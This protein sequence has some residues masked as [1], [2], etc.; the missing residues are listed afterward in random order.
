MLTKVYLEGPLG[1]KFGREWEFEVSSPAEALRMVDA[2]VPGVFDWIKQNLKQFPNYRVVIE[3]D[4]GHMEELDNDTVAMNSSMR[5]IRFVPII[6]GAGA[7]GRIVLGAVLIAVSFIP[8]MQWTFNIGLSMV[9]G[10]IIGALSPKPSLSNSPMEQKEN[11]NKTSYYFDGPVNTT[12]QGV[13]VQLI[14][15]QI[16]VGSHVISAGMTVDQLI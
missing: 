14:Y 4:D 16:L 9:I 5:E 2:N 8:G 15:G 10:G 3:R 6:E 1:K 7:F 12:A 11:K 13:P